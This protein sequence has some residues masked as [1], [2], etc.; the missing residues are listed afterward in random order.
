MPPGSHTVYKVEQYQSAYEPYVIMSK[1]VTWYV[2]EISLT[3]VCICGMLIKAVF[4]RCDERFTGYRGN[5]AA[6]LF[7]LYLSGVSYYVMSDHFLIHQSHTYEE[8]ARREEVSF[9]TLIYRYVR[10]TRFHAFYPAQV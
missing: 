4:V 2:F 6:C 7:E 5:K 1:R 9:I 3:F 10:L 8:E